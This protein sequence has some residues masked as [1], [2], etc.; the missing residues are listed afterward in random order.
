MLVAAQS[1]NSSE[2]IL[3][4]R[5]RSEASFQ[6]SAADFRFNRQTIA[7]SLRTLHSALTPN[8]FFGAR[9]SALR[10]KRDLRN[11]SSA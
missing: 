6:G 10:G 2:T 4:D 9:T 8:C 11:R 1:S 7:G 3:H 5:L